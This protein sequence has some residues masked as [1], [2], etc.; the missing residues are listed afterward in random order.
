MYI[1]THL[2]IYLVCVSCRT[3][4]S[5]ETK[6]ND[7]QNSLRETKRGSGTTLHKLTHPLLASPLYVWHGMYVRTRTDAQ[8][9]LAHVRRG[10][11]TCAR[12]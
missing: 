1:Y 12:R 10:T 6:P 3:I 5:E 2:S 8:A 4:E 9:R 7:T 11:V